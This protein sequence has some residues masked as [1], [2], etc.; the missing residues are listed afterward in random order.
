MDLFIISL[1]L[2]VAL[3]LAALLWGFDSHAWPDC[4]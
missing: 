2:L 3:D 4:H 1:I